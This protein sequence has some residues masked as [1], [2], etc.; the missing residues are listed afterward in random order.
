MIAIF[1]V[2]LLGAIAGLLM[3]LMIALIIE[4]E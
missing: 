1:C 3:G 2:F 4:W